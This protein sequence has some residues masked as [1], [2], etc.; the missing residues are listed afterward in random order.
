MFIVNVKKKVT[1]SKNIKFFT[2]V[3]QYFFIQNNTRGID[4]REKE[5]IEHSKTNT[6]ATAPIYIFLKK[7]SGDDDSG[8]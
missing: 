4:L 6:I 8:Y 7:L 3:P 1:I 2:I 5:I